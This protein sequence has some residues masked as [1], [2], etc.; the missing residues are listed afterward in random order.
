MQEDLLKEFFEVAFPLLDK[1]DKPNYY[2]ITDIIE[3]NKIL[4]CAKKVITL[5][6]CLCYLYQIYYFLIQNKTYL[7]VTKQNIRV[8]ALE[9]KIIQF[10]KKCFPSI[11]ENLNAEQL[12]LFLKLLE[13]LNNIECVR[14]DYTNENGN[15]GRTI[16]ST[17]HLKQIENLLNEKEELSTQLKRALEQH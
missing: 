10:L 12:Y 11:Q 17:H 7:E 6:T 16:A 2:L 3:S 4:Q 8:F 5:N 14:Q 9:R 1:K 13:N 15:A